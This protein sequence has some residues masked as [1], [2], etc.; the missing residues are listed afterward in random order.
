VV[1]SNASADVL[2]GKDFIVGKRKKAKNSQ[3]SAE[4]S[5]GG[6]VR[7]KVKLAKLSSGSWSA[8][9]ETEPAPVEPVSAAKTRISKTKD[10]DPGT[11]LIDLPKA[12]E[13]F[14]ADAKVDGKKKSSHSIGSVNAPAINF[15]FT[16]KAAARKPSAESISGG[17]LLSPAKAPP[18]GND[19]PNHLGSPVS[20]S[21]DPVEVT[22]GPGD[23]LQS[24]PS[25]MKRKRKLPARLA[26]ANFLLGS[27]ASGCPSPKHRRL[28]E[29]SSSISGGNSGLAE[30]GHL[31][32]AAGGDPVDIVKE[33]VVKKGKRGRR[34]KL[35]LVYAE[36]NAPIVNK[37][38]PDKIKKPRLRNVPIPRKHVVI[39]SPGVVVTWAARSQQ[40]KSGK[41]LIQE[42][43][44]TMKKARSE[45]MEIIKGEVLGVA[46]S[47]GTG[48]KQELVSSSQASKSPG[49]ME[50]GGEKNAPTVGTKKL[51]RPRKVTFLSVDDLSLAGSSGTGHDTSRGPAKKE[52]SVAKKMKSGNKPKEVS[53]EAF[54]PSTESKQVLQERVDSS[55]TSKN[56]D[57]EPSGEKLTVAETTIGKKKVGRPRKETKSTDAHKMLL[58]GGGQDTS[59]KF[60]K[61]GKSVAKKM[62]KSGD[63][64]RKAELLP[65]G[66]AS[67]GVDSKQVVHGVAITSL[68]SKN[69]G[70]TVGK[71]KK[72]G[73]PRKLTDIST[74]KDAHKLSSGSQEVQDISQT[75]GKNEKSLLSKPVLQERVNFNQI[76]KQKPEGKKVSQEVATGTKKK[77]MGG[78]RQGRNLAG[79]Q[80]AMP[81]DGKDAEYGCPVLGCS[82]SC[83]EVKTFYTLLNFES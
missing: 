35:D 69:S 43:K 3:D 16:T 58:A 30:T 19:K 83:S 52:K 71:I 57:K 78:F 8:V 67:T 60:S 77:K 34:P 65:L 49:K 1:E 61:K 7:L 26:D 39:S 79:G 81:Q 37:T 70:E 40:K 38:T 45:E 5:S 59:Q 14:A 23:S 36:A 66:G 9:Q 62:K 27:S 33:P 44:S 28:S 18:E 29:S 22:T 50:P 12:G 64:Q 68:T 42:K 31:E 74:S 76:S 25:A 15:T 4:S 2:N 51:G 6:S 21:A 10:I 73:R 32:M 63:K 55:Q 56:S 54:S 46:S 82:W 80:D 53:P 11:P 47:P 13:D 48:S 24:P 41:K 17:M 20:V 72:L 75:L